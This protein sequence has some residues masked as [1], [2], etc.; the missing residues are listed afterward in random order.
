MKKRAYNRRQVVLG[1]GAGSMLTACGQSQ[2][3][4]IQTS[5]TQKIDWKM[6]TTWPKNFPGL[7]SAAQHLADQV[8]I[9]SGGRLNIRVYGAGERVPALETF[10]AVSR[11]AAEMG[12]GASYYWK[13]KSP[14]APFF[15]A[16][17]FGLTAQEMNGWLYFGGGL[18][19][20][21]ELY[22]GFNLVPFEA[23]NTGTQM[24]GWFRKPI[25]SLATLQGV[26][27]RIPG[28]GGEVMQRIGVTTVNIPGGELFTALQT[29]AIDATEWVSPYNDLAFGLH[30]VAKHYYY[31]G[32]Q[33]PGATLEA[34]I[35][36]D[37][38]N[39][40]PQ[41][42]QA[43]VANACQA[44]STRMLAEYAA[45]NQQALKTLVEEHSVQ[46]H[47]FPG[48]VLTALREASTQVLQELTANDSFSRRVYDSYKDYRAQIVQSTAI[49]EQAY[50]NARDL[51]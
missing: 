30:K 19:L 24:G 49:M 25:D 22:D 46:V 13:G 27:M 6:V 44:T 21:R 16:V 39:A 34:I 47:A 18:E 48:D 37:A 23:G 8:G 29:G 45:R 11:G 43:I 12:H 50:L 32:W 14:A 20:W 31:P 5:K 9:M 33:E 7:G 51:T 35:N 2:A 17:P 1:L 15:T 10:D 36:K 4:S 38:W 28:L 3:P 41:D 40:L 26:K 42:L